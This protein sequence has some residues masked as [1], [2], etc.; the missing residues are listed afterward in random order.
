MTQSASLIA[1]TGVYN[2]SEVIGNVI[3][4]A[5]HT[6]ANNARRAPRRV[7]GVEVLALAGTTAVGMHERSDDRK[8]LDVGVAGQLQC[9][10]TASIGRRE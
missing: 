7:H 8:H 10:S 6:D 5:R 2:L 3:P 1:R 4:V 9:Q